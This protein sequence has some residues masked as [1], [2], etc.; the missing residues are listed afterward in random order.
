METDW[1]AD[2]VKQTDIFAGGQTEKEMID[3]PGRDS[4]ADQTETSVPTRERVGGGL[5]SVE[6][7][8]NGS[9]IC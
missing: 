8:Q 7:C 6:I 3:R 2:T 1:C 9:R 4:C 5:K